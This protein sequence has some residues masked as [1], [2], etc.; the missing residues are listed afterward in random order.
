MPYKEPQPGDIIAV[1]FDGTIVEKKFPL[2]GGWKPRALE[3][4]KKLY[5]RGYKLILWTCRE[6]H[7]YDPDK[8]YL[9][10]AKRRCTEHGL[11][12]H[13]VNEHLFRPEFPDYEYEHNRKPFADWYIDDHSPL[14]EEIDWEFLGKFFGV[15]EK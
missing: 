8:Q 9:R 10:D 4:L 14:I 15:L 5:N 1:D 2:I 6:D 11:Y 13:A 12:F 3:V 7:V